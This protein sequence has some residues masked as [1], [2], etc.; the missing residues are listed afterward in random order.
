MARDLG[1][2]DS[3]E[4]SYDYSWDDQDY[5]QMQSALEYSGPEEDDYPEVSNGIKMGSTWRSHKPRKP[6]TSDEDIKLCEMFNENTDISKIA[7]ELGRT[8]SSIMP[9]LIDLCF[10]LRNISIQELDHIPKNA[11][12]DPSHT[13]R[14]RKGYDLGYQIPQIARVLNRSSMNVARKLITEKIV[15]PQPT[16]DNPIH[17]NAE[18]RN[19]NLAFLTWN[20]W[21]S[22]QPKSKQT[23]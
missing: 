6:W 22:S 16:S 13:E 1:G 3:R 20:K 17:A 14:L 4:F 15:I 18:V 10:R 8:K 23:E 9:R 11:A 7:S 19:E 5:E 2:S 21:K 12:W